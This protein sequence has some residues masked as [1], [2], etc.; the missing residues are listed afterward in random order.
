MRNQ[1][2]R[3]PLDPVITASRFAVPAIHVPQ[4]IAN[5]SVQRVVR[6]EATLTS[7]APVF[8]LTP[9]ALMYQDG[10]D[11]LATMI[12]R[13]VS[14]RV[15]QCRIWAESPN[16]LSVSQNPYGIVVV[17]TLSGFS[18][19]DRPNTGAALSAVG[20]RFPFTIRST[21]FQ[22][23]DLT[24]LLTVASDQTI[25]TSTDFLVTIDTTV[26]FYG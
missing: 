12:N 15:V 22:A 4:H 2:S 26:E 8:T 1:P 19:T 17:E 5:P 7:A 11:Y 23:F 14:M 13:Y 20:I 9:E 16:N 25:A 21:V 18:I 10:L 24:S 6:I 3:R